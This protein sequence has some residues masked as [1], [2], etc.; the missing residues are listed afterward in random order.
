[1]KKGFTLLEM[2]TVLVLITLIV[3]ITYS[4]FQKQIE[5]SKQKLY[6]N[7]INMIEKAGKDY[8]LMNLNIKGVMISTLLGTD[9][10][11]N[12]TIVNPIDKSTI[13]GCVIFDENSYN[14]TEYVYESDLNTCLVNAYNSYNVL[15]DS[16]VVLLT[17]L[18]NTNYI[19]LSDITI[20]GNVMT[21]CMMLVNDEVIYESN[22]SNCN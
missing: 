11:S 16:E 3:S 10:I 13:T 9:L 14:Q 7:Q 15:Y 6:D 21:G 17:E 2:L 18:V 22:V 8:N 19:S 12:E 4:V 20:S 1:M 5:T